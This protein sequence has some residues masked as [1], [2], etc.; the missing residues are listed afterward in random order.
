MLGSAL[1][2]GRAVVSWVSIWLGGSSVVECEALGDEVEQV[3]GADTWRPFKGYV[4]LLHALLVLSV[5]SSCWA[6]SL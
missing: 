1:S 6:R 4:G 5:L 3:W 2:P